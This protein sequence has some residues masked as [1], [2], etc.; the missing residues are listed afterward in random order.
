MKIHLRPLA[1]EETDAELLW[2]SVSLAAAGLG[3]FWLRWH[4]PLPEC[5][6]A[7]WTGLPCPTCG[8]TRLVRAVL[9]GNAGHAFALNPLLFLALLAVSGV[10]FYSAVVLA[11]RLRRV[12]CGKFPEKLGHIIRGAAV[13]LFVANW[14]YLVC[15]LP[16]GRGESRAD[17]HSRGAVDFHVAHA[18]RG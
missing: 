3:V 8:G 13:I 14:L 15:T 4:L 5:P 6:F 17:F 10:F 12:R 9:E 1:P 7:H 2:V 11:F 16:V 18:E